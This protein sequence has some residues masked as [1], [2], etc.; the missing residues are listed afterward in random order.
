MTGWVVV[1]I[2]L[3]TLPFAILVVGAYLLANRLADRVD[4]DDATRESGDPQ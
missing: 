4:R 1:V 3:A 2:G